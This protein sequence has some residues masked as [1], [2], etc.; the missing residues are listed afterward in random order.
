M[1]PAVDSLLLPLFFYHPLLQQIVH[2]G[3]K[4]NGWGLGGLALRLP[5]ATPVPS[6]AS[7]HT[8]GVNTPA[9]TSPLPLTAF[10][11]LD[12]EILQLLPA[13]LGHS[14]ETHRRHLPQH[15]TRRCHLLAGQTEMCPQRSYPLVLPPLTTGV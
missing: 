10:G 8:E 9:C 15:R 13:P 3:P 4:E 6:S 7:V 12:A 14:P 5:L 1:V 11:P 2:C